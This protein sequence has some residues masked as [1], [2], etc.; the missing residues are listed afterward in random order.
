MTKKVKSTVFYIYI[1]AS[2][3]LL[4]FIIFLQDPQQSMRMLPERSAQQV[5]V[6]GAQSIILE[7]FQDPGE[8]PREFTPYVSENFSTSSGR[9]TQERGYNVTQDPVPSQNQENRNTRT[10]QQT[11]RRIHRNEDNP[12][13]LLRPY[14]SPY[15]RLNV[16][17]LKTQDHN[18]FV[19]NFNKDGMAS[20]AT[21]AF[22]NVKYF[23]DIAKTSWQYL[24][25]F[26]PKD[27][28][29][30]GALKNSAVLVGFT[31]DRQGNIKDIWV[32]DSTNSETLNSLSVRAIDFIKTQVG[33]FGPQP[34]N[35]DIKVV[36]V[37]FYV[38]RDF[39]GYG[40]E[41]RPVYIN[42]Q[43]AFYFEYKNLKN[44]QP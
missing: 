12:D 26:A 33:G 7:S 27:S 8:R 36:Y 2:L 19:L 14:Q 44:N 28:I 17:R 32:V 11:T 10:Q 39:S 29:G 6:P 18:R 35:Y 1:A 37:Y 34:N 31:L 16:P 13:I 20:F 15:P 43:G 4:G 9:M 5:K 21:R 25:Q 22:P 3:H 40:D 41:N 38:G 23:I 42:L 30:M 24:V